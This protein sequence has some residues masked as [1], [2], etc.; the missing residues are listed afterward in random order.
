[1]NI[2]TTIEI[3]RGDLQELQRDSMRLRGSM[4]LFW[5]LPLL[6]A[7]YIAAYFRSG[8]SDM[9][10][11]LG[12]FIVLFPLMMMWGMRRQAARTKREN[13]SFQRPIIY[14]ITGESLETEAY[15]GT[16]RVLWDDAWYGQEGRANYYV[17]I[18]SMQ[19]MILPRRAFTPEEQAELS[20]LFAERFPK[21]PF[22]GKRILF[23]VLTAFIGLGGLGML[24]QMLL[25]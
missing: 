15:Q 3:T 5:V 23:A 24:L 8:W 20:A 22:R 1:M 2:E 12:V 4:M 13:P 9:A 10:L 17:Y 25:A 6:G 19:A 16:S 21:K 14:R 7:V 11:F 18:S